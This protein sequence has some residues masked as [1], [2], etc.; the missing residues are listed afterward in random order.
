MFHAAKHFQK[1]FLRSIGRVCRIGDDA[2]HKAVNWLV[3]FRD[4]PGVG[5]FRSCLKFR[6]DRRLLGPDSYRDCKITQGGC[7]RHQSHGVTSPL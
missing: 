1:N 6:H 4:E 7:S 5:V 2:I 3:K